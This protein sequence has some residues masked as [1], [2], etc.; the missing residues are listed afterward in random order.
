M[1]A[2]GNHLRTWQPGLKNRH[3]TLT[4]NL[5]RQRCQ[6]GGFYYRIRSQ[7]GGWVM[8]GVTICQDISLGNSHEISN[9]IFWR[10]GDNLLSTDSV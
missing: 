10:N 5:V 9:F 2:R 8:K 3:L 7:Y 4:K 6:Y 1:K